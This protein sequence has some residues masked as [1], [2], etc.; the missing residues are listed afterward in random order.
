[1]LQNLDSLEKFG[2]LKRII[3][4]LKL[5]ALMMVEKKDKKKQQKIM[6][7]NQALKL[8][9]NLVLMNFLTG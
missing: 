5:R 9:V 7:R 4:S 8:Q 2:E 6:L 1:V 3:T